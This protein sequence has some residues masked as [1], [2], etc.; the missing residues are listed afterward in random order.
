MLAE[1]I[2]AVASLAV[3][4]VLVILAARGLRRLDRHGPRGA[5]SDGTV[6]IE[7]LARRSLSR[8][9]SVAV[10]RIGERDLVVGVTD[11]QVTVLADTL[12]RVHPA[13][14]PTVTPA[15]SD[16]S[17]VVPPGAAPTAGNLLAVLR[18]K[19]GRA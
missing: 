9:S 15:G 10:L 16:A 19:Q 13:P 6:G 17:P 18:D 2:K 12:D 7:I 1:V 4:L 3:V 14:M 8:R 5:R 11:A